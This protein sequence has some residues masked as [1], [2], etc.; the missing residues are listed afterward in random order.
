MNGGLKTHY[1]KVIRQSYQ[2]VGLALALSLPTLILHGSSYF[3][4]IP[5]FL[6]GKI[7]DEFGDRLTELSKIPG[8]GPGNY[9]GATQF[10]VYQGPY[11]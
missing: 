11:R 3:V 5:W 6:A 8:C 1:S 2:L 4:R 7:N 10:S 9:Q